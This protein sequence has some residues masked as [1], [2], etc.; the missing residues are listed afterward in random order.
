[1][2]GGTYDVYPDH[3]TYTGL[4]TRSGDRNIGI[5]TALS[6]VDASG[7][8]TQSECVN[9]LMAGGSTIN[10]FDAPEQYIHYGGPQNTYIYQMG[11]SAVSFPWRADGTGNLAVQAY[12][13]EPLYFKDGN[14]NN[15]GGSVSFGLYL[16]NERTG[17]VLNYVIGLYAAGEAW[18][19]EKRGILFD[20]TT[21]FVHVGTVVSDD[22]WWTTISP[23]SESITEVLPSTTTRGPDDG[24]WPHFFRVNIAYQNLE[25]LLNELAEN[26]PEGATGQEFGHNPEEWKVT[27]IMLQYEL[28]EEGGKAI[29]SGSF[30]GFE[31]YRSDL[32]I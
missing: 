20:P 22:S 10:L 15:V 27:G 9:G 30:R 29:M 1:M 17:V 8:M 4:D 19:E 18:V 14:S 25:A 28:E 23:Q 2:N 16:T 7:S 3:S 6:Q 24:Q 26:P 11:D 21:K 31:V 13:D 5:G 12:F 32:P